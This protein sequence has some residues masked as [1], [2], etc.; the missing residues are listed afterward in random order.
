[1]KLLEQ[2][3]LIRKQRLPT[4]SN[5]DDSFAMRMAHQQLFM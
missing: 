3:W 1:M 4:I 2:N 5:F